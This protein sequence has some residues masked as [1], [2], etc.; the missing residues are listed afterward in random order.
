MQGYVE[1]HARLGSNLPCGWWCMDGF[2]MDGG[3]R[4][5]GVVWAVEYLGTPVSPS[6]DHHCSHVIV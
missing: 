6:A 4:F 5:A 2:V 3:M 1:I